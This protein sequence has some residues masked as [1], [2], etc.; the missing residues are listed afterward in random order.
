MKKLLVWSIIL[1]VVL[2][3]ILCTQMPPE[4]AVRYAWVI[5]PLVL[6][7]QP[8]LYYAW[9][10]LV[11][12]CAPVRFCGREPGPEP[13]HAQGEQGVKLTSIPLPPGDSVLVRDESYTA[14]YT[15]HADCRLKKS[16]CLIFSWKYWFM[17][18][19]CGLRMLTRFTNPAQ[20]ERAL[21]ISITSNDP[22][23]YFAVINVEPGQRYYFTPSDLVA[24]SG[25]VEI[26][27][28]W[29]LWLPAWCMGQVRAYV[30]SGRGTVVVRA[31]GGITAGHLENGR[32]DVRK[33]H[34]LICASQGVHLHVRRTET[35]L[36]YLLGRADLFDLRLTGNGAY[37]IR[38]S[39]ERPFGAGLGQWL[40]F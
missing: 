3:G 19:T 2:W 11:E 13:A 16:I 4:E 37:C 14:G 10:P 18:Y 21:D 33:L 40:G 34:S 27:A 17:S 1:F 20:N 23:E 36:S 25:G 22:D 26:H 38:N 28:R 35:F 12:S 8:L 39:M 7:I 32:E 5:I 29:R 24:I 31:I 15:E 30:L 6:C 9:A